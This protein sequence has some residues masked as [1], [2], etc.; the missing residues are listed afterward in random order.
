MEVA[1]PR[2]TWPPSTDC[3]YSDSPTPPSPAPLS[4]SKALDRIAAFALLALLSL[5]LLLVLVLVIRTDSGPAFFR[6]K[7]VGLG[8][9][10][11]HMIKFC[12]VVVDAEARLAELEAAN[13]GAGPSSSCA[14]IHA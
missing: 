11:F 10:E 4:C 1:G 3:P 6:Q 2:C 14:M 8:G 7:R 5:L 12:T 9:R 13:E